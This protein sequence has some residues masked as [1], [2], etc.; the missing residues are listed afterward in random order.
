MNKLL[1]KI[2]FFIIIYAMSL[3]IVLLMVI[4]FDSGIRDV[5]S[6]TLLTVSI[7]FI[8]PLPIILAIY[9]WLGAKELKRDYEQSLIVIQDNHI[10]TIQSLDNHKIL[11]NVHMEKIDTLEKEVSRYKRVID[12]IRVKYNQDKAIPFADKVNDEEELHIC[13]D[14][15]SEM[16]ECPTMFICNKCKKRVKKQ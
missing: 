4:I 8:R 5:M 16:R 1:D 3:G 13:P 9:M 2:G 12:E 15:K 14:C 11:K 7:V 10:E 6:H